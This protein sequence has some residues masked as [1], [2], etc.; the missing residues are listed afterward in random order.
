MIKPKKLRNLFEDRIF[1]VSNILSLSRVLMLPVFY[2]FTKNYANDP[3]DIRFLYYSIIVLITAVLTDYLDGLIARMMNEQSVLGRYLDPICDK[4]TTMV[5]MGLVVYYFHFPL[6]LLITYVMRE[7]FTFYMGAFLYFKRG[8]QG[9]PNWWGKFGVGI[10]AIEIFWYMYL[11][12]W[13]NIHHTNDWTTKPEIATYILLMV[14]GLGLI[15]YT[16]RYWNIVFH[17]QTIKAANDLKKGGKHFHVV[18]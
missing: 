6:W 7:I 14:L 16:K 12:Y 15:T 17:P 10:V 13:K 9:K 4:I 5:S 2:Y 1:T 3:T 11:P 18:E 8:I